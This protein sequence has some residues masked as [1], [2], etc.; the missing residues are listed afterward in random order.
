MEVIYS[1]LSGVRR[2]KRPFWRLR[3]FCRNV[4]YSI[5]DFLM[6]IGGSEILSVVW[7]FLFLK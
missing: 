6:I 3:R 7:Y 2:L 1:I 5:A 4:R